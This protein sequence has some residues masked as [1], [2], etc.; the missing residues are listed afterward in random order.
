VRWDD[1]Q[2]E[3]HYQ[4]WIRYGQSKLCNLLFA[5]ELDRRLRSR[6]LPV[7]SLAAHPGYSATNLQGER[8]RMTGSAFWATV[9]R[10]V[11]A[12]AAQPAAMGALPSLY[13]A[14]APDVHGGEL[15]GPSGLFELWGSPRR[16]SSNRRSRDTKAAARLWEVSEA[17][18]GV[19]YAALGAA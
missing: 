6:S 12:I 10:W 9:W 8:A 15:F 3:R 18:T 16:V 13:A 4:T 19:R 5:Y 14:T 11:N 7:M 17:L 1:L 2:A